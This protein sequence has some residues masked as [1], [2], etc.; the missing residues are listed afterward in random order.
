MDYDTWCFQVR[1]RAAGPFADFFNVICSDEEPLFNG[2]TGLR[3]TY[4]AQLPEMIDFLL[5]ELDFDIRARVPNHVDYNEAYYRR[6]RP[7]MLRIIRECMME[8]RGNLLT[9]VSVIPTGF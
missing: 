1:A 5:E 9:G 7:D 6:N 8:A 4:L 2:D 3:N